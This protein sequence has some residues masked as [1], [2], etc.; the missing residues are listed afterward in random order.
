M[1]H[2]MKHIRYVHN[3]TKYNKF[4]KHASVTKMKGYHI[5]LTR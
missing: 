4:Y 5:Y 1:Q 3:N 2:N